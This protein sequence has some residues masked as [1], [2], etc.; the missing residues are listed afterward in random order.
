LVEA[1]SADVL[2]RRQAALI[3]RLDR[4]MNQ[5]KMCVAVTV[6][7]EKRFASAAGHNGPDDF[8]VVRLRPPDPEAPPR[9]LAAQKTAVAA[10]AERMNL[11]M[12]PPRE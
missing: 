7:D 3:A 6:A 11:D 10:P 2:A 12:E 4:E 9:V 5:V 8:W 1:L